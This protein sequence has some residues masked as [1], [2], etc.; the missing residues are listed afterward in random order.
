MKYV[1]VLKSADSGDRFYVGVT[2][3]LKARLS[4]HNAGE[5]A[6]TAK[7]RPWTLKTYVAFL[8]ESKAFAFERYLKSG[9]GRAFAKRHL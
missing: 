5:V 8:D 2:D 3:D 6:H 7:Y 4:R 1:Y 9:S